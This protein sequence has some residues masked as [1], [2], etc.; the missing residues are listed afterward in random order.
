M[1]KVGGAVFRLLPV[2]RVLP[3]ESLYERLLGKSHGARELGQI[4]GLVPINPT[5]VDFL[6]GSEGRG[7]ARGGAPDADKL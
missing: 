3:F 4:F 2:F 1:K 6:E 7:G 5:N